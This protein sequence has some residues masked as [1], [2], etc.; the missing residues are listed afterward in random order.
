MSTLSEKN[1][2][3]VDNLL[4]SKNI[5]DRFVKEINKK[6]EGEQDTIKAIFLHLMC[7]YV[8]NTVSLPHVFVNSESS[9]GK[10]YI[11]KKITEIFPRGK[12]EYRTKISPEAFTYWHNSKYE[13]EW[14]WEGK[15]C[16]LE[17]VRD[18]IINSPT[19]KVMASEGSKATVVYK[20][21]AIDIEIRGHPI[22]IVTS[23]SA[24]PN[25][26]IINRFSIVNLDE[27]PEQTNRIKVKQVEEAIMGN[28][29]DYNPI[30]KQVL[31]ELM[32]CEVR[33]PEWLTKIV[34]YFPDD[35]L[36]IRRDFPRF[37]DL[38]KASAALHQQQREFDPLT[39]IVFADEKDYE[40]A[41]NVMEKLD[42]SGGVFGLTYRLRMCYEACLKY[43]ESD[44]L[45][46][47]AK[48]MFQFSPLVTEKSWKN[49]LDR[50]A[51]DGILKVGLEE[52]HYSKKPITVFKPKVVFKLSLPSYT[53]LLSE[54]KVVNV[55]KIDKERKG[56]NET[57]PK[58]K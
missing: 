46:F 48:D 26:E 19:F 27:T 21:R 32:R 24:I 36:R 22:M 25:S 16:Y 51:R 29:E 43:Y 6:V 58:K 3:L 20:Q 57:S 49:I 45:S 30:F 52:R 17:D 4:E 37:L 28:Y 2:M 41:R 50:L 1:D 56:A 44:H 7:S 42:T 12:V 33:L 23:A 39:K 54:G 38:M 55:V 9:S 11:C 31:S 53:S 13:E 34:N 10:S 40:T 8:K 14:T 18:D 47:S 35:V 5:L 15:I